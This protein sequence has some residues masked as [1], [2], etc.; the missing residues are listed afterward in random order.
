MGV[1]DIIIA[2]L[3]LFLVPFLRTYFP[4]LS[5]GGR[6]SIVSSNKGGFLSEGGVLSSCVGIGSVDTPTLD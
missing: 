4:T 1:A 2:E 3:W 5:V 6:L